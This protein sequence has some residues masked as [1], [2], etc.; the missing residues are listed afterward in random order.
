MGLASQSSLG[1]LIAGLAIF[2]FQRLHVGDRLQIQTP[3]GLAT[4]I[5][6]SMTLSYTTLRTSEHEEIMVPNNVLVNSIIIRL[7][8]KGQEDDG[9]SVKQDRSKPSA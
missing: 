2:L 5:V 1:N 7:P 6:E 3:K 8:S 9:S 4:G